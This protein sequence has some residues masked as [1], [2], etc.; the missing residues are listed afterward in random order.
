MARLRSVAHFLAVTIAAA[1]ILAA[2]GGGGGG[3]GV[4][5][6]RVAVSDPPLADLVRRVAGERFEVVAVVPLGADG[7]TYEP[8]PSDARA[9]N[10]ARLYIENGL[11]LNVTVSAFARDQLPAETPVVALARTIPPD[12]IIP[13]ESPEQVAAHGHAHNFNAHL[14]PDPVYAAEYVRIIETALVD[15]DPEGADG[16]RQRAAA[17]GA[18]I[19]ALE[20]AIRTAIDTIPPA[21]RKLLVY[22]DAWSYF[23]RRFGI[24]VIGTI[25][26]VNF[27]E[28]SAAEVRRTI[29]QVRQSGVPAFF[30]S[31]VFPTDVLKTIA[32]ATGSRYV[33]D[34]SDDRMPGKPGDAE[35]GYVGMMVQNARTIVS[36]LGG[37]AG[38]LDAVDPRKR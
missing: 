29:D 1:S 27:S 17:L 23:G 12:E 38:A 33:G 32:E 30:G 26:P 6:P 15:V 34:L 20:N 36:A 8:R 22:H 10:G 2:C 21:N 37:N 5:R 28:P 7:H 35:H 16:F 13:N 24:P 3:G 19:K 11:G 9:L 4:S 18:E 14:W 25:Q 31:E